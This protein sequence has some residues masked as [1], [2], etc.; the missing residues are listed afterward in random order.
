VRSA[1]GWYSDGWA[2]PR[3]EFTFRAGAG[4]HLALDVSLPG[5]APIAR[6]RLTFSTGGKTFASESFG[7]GAFRIPVMLPRAV[8]DRPVT[9]QVRA[10]AHFRSD[11]RGERYDRRKLAYLLRS[12]DFEETSEA[13][14][15][16]TR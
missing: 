7:H 16:P 2:A 6:Q 3:A 8:W 11:L 15:E 5:W 14:A 13:S 10:A 4:R 9:V 1:Q 12:F